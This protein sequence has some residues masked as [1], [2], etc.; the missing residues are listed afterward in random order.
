MTHLP[1]LPPGQ[2]ESTEFPAFGLPWFAFRL[3][4]K[5]TPLRL[6]VDGDLATKRSFT[7]DELATLPRVEQTSDFH[8][9]T[10][11]SVRGVRWGGYRFV[12]FYEQIVAGQLEPAAGAETVVL[13]GLDG[14]ETT[15][16]LQDLMR[17][18]IMLADTVE[19]GPLTLKHGAPLRL[20]AP[21]NYGFKNVK[22][23]KEISFWR[24]VRGHVSPVMAL[25]AHPRGRAALEERGKLPGAILRRLYRP[26]VNQTVWLFEKFLQRR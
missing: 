9:V 25:L 24:D 21:P 10:T 11:W 17:D 16:P 8:C 15:L 5:E 19:G 26:I 7:A 3:P 12:D 22:F 13:R 6:R 4:R 23:L 1:N 2:R 14:Y 20:V 18:D